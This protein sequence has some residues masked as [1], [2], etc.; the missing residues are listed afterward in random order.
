MDYEYGNR[1]RTVKEERP[2]GTRIDSVTYT[3]LHA[4]DAADRVKAMTYPGGEA[5]TTVYNSQELPE[6]LT[7]SQVYVTEAGY[8]A[9]GQKK[10]Y[11]LG[12]GAVSTWTY[13]GESPV[14]NYPSFRLWEAS[15]TVGGVD[16]QK[17]HYGY[18]A[19][20]NVT[21]IEDLT[22][23][24]G[25][26]TQTFTYDAFDRLLTANAAGGSAGQG[27]GQYGESYVYNSIGNLTS[28]GGV[29]YNYPPSGEDSVQPHAVTSTTAG[30]AFSYDAA[31]NMTSRK[32]T[33]AGPTYT[34]TWNSE[35][36]LASVT[37]G[38]V[39]TNF[40]YDG[41]GTLVKKAVVGGQTTVYVGPHYER[42]VTTGQETRYYF[43]GP[44][45]V[46][47]RA[48]ACWFTITS[49][50]VSCGCRQTQ[51]AWARRIL[52]RVVASHTD[53]SLHPRCFS[54][55]RMRAGQSNTF[56]GSPAREPPESHTNTRL[57]LTSRTWSNAPARTGSIMLPDAPGRNRHG[58][59]RRC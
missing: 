55:Y 26:Q 57:A 37:V 39:T 22:V 15:T 56:T 49:T 44:D 10:R 41:N 20:G 3:T 17:L 6:T 9:L 45:R 31:G 14:E 29:T 24:G 40:V 58:V 5:V 2:K 23:L 27:Q 54:W 36:R 43:F 25:T 16:R 33:S 18:D 30:G 46:A 35:T 47:M 7:G 12:H 28:K 13:Y 19:A 53:S 32:L 21:S 51:P 34:Q 50:S 1:G 42:N 4:F 59:P 48:G 11:T 38:G 8:T 52:L